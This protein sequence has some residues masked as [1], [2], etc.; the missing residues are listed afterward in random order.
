M[1]RSSSC[2]AALVAGIVVLCG[3]FA[4]AGTQSVVRSALIQLI[5]VVGLYIYSGIP[6]SCRRADKLHGDR[7][8]CECAPDRPVMQKH[9]LWPDFP[10]AGQF[11]LDRSSTRLPPPS[12]PGSPP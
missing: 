8:L 2:P 3:L 1:L 4:D 9:F 12:S 11:V 6:G 7:R 5:L 10:S